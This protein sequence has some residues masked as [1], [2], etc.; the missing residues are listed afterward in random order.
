MSERFS[1][2][3][4]IPSEPAV[5]MLARQDAKL[6]TPLTSPAS[7][8]VSV[9]LTELEAA[10]AWVDMVRLMSVALPPRECVWW[11][12]LAARD[13]VGEE[14]TACVKAAEAWV[15]EPNP[16]N[17]LAVQTVLNTADGDDDTALTATAALYAPGTLGV[18][19]E[20]ADIPAP[21]GAVAA[22]CF[23]MNLATLELSDDPVQRLRLVFERALDI[24]KGGNG[25]VEMPPP[26]EYEPL[27]DDDDE[28][29]TDEM[30]DEEE[31]ETAEADAEAD[32]EDANT[33]TEKEAI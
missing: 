22:A 2:L 29:E 28:D 17:R 24:A 18:E 26:T 16:T 20:V 14:G 33:D 3:K 7:A 6:E 15:F 8:S 12:C 5:R 9:V 27:E 25:R 23:G 19:G 21:P 4:K 13:I 11:A 10:G 30:S 1:E 31:V 32:A